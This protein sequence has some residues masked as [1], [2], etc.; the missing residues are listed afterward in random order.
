MKGKI[1]FIHKS[2][3][4]YAAVLSLLLSALNGF[5]TPSFALRAHAQEASFEA[6][7][8]VMDGDGEE[9]NHITPVYSG[10]GVITKLSA[11][12]ADGTLYG[13]ME[14][15][16]SANFDTWH[17]YFDTNEDS[18]DHL[19]F[20]GADYLLETDILYVYKGDSGEWEGLE[21]T[22]AIVERGLSSD[23]K[24]LEFAIPLADMGDPAT[25]G[26]H[27]ATVS[28]WADVADCPMTVGEYL[29][30]PTLEEVLS[31][32]MTGLTEQELEA[33]LASKEFAGTKT[34]WNSILYDA[35]NRNSNLYAL[36]AV[37]DRENLYIHASAKKLSNNFT[38]TILTDEAQYECKANGNIFRIKDGKRV[39]TGTPVKNFYKADNGFEIVIP[40]SMLEGGNDRYEVCIDDEERNSRMQTPMIRTRSAIWK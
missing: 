36:K 23:K 12:T 15:S 18:T 33:Y 27:A 9:W 38:V 26:I 17:I 20:T 22:N 5:M 25:I 7:S 3:A 19:Y 24:T 4:V 28:N 11:F 34:Q 39:D 6:P 2:M 8:F 1:R 32:E 21:G 16:S 29:V 35:V 40:V 10:G 13:K 31:E 14:L 37:T 30:V